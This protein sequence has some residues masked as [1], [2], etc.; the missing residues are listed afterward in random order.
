MK[1]NVIEDEPKSLIVEFEELDR[2]IPDLIRAKL[3]ENK[4]VEFAS[5]VIDHPEV[6]KP[7]LT[8]KAS[9]SPRGQ[10]TKA[11][12]KLQEELEDLEKQLPKK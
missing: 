9:K 6:N 10:V 1:V 3:E 11:I 4:D 2:S 7:R 12:E 8:V 5:V